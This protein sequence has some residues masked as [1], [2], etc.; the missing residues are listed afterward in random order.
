VTVHAQ[1]MGPGAL[2]IGSVGTALDLT[3]QVT[4]CKVTPSASAED[5]VP[6]LSGETLAGER[7]YSWTLSATL[8][9]D[10]T[11]A[12]MFDYTWNNKGTEVPFQFTPSTAAGRTVS[13]TV[14][15]DPLEL[16]GDVKKKNTTALEWVIVG[17]PVL[18]TD[19]A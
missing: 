4:A 15:V 14:V 1:V 2:S 3:A 8:I 6:T 10:L 5:S 13:G 12:G 17:D 7:T 19:L 11:E 16:G 9:Q 18:G